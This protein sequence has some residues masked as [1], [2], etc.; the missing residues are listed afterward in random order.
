M[1]EIKFRAWDK[2]SKSINEIKSLNFSQ[3]GLDCHLELI[4]GTDSSVI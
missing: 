1:R 2:K 4:L 3:V